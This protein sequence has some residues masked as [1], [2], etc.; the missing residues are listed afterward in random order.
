[1]GTPQGWGGV[2][3]PPQFN[4]PPSR[5][6]TPAT[7][8][9]VPAH[10]GGLH[11]PSFRRGAQ[12]PGGVPHFPRRGM[13]PP[14]RG[15]PPPRRGV[16]CCSP[17]RG[18]PAPAGF[19]PPHGWEPLPRGV[20]QPW[21]G[22]PPQ[23]VY[24]RPSRRGTPLSQEGYSRCTEGV[25]HLP[26]G[27]RRGALASKEGAPPHLLGGAPSP[28]GSP[29]KGTHALK[30]GCPTPARGGPQAGGGWGWEEECSMKAEIFFF[31][32][33]VHPPGLRP[34]GEF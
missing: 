11:P 16:P 33:I 31:I 1:M 22:T 6:G 9:G 25:P 18:T 19:P 10:L 14:R 20:P 28:P 34:P 7:L 2:L 30:E 15:A 12:P 29:R 17:R 27:G 8:D 5:G 21:R 24:P 13:L 23:E 4:A 3:T 32:S 26:G